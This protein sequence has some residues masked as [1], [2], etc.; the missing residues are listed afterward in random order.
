MTNIKQEK[1]QYCKSMKS[2]HT[3]FRLESITYETYEKL[4]NNFF[5]YNYRLYNF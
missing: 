2:I 4:Q 3:L 1:T 5:G